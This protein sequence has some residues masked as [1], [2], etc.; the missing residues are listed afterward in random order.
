MKKAVL[1]F[2]SRLPEPMPRGSIGLGASSR[3]DRATAPPILDYSRYLGLPASPFEGGRPVLFLMQQMDDVRVEAV[4]GKVGELRDLLFDEQWKIR[5]LVVAGGTWLKQRRVTLPPTMIEENNWAHRELVIGGLT[6][7]QV[8]ASPETEKHIP[9][10]Q[11]GALEDVTTIA[12]D[13]YWAQLALH[14]WQVASDPELRSVGAVTGYQVE[15][16]DATLG[17]LAD[18][19]ID[20]EAWTIKYLAVDT[21]PWRK[22]RVL[23]VAPTHVT[24]LD[25]ETRTMR[26]G[27]S[28]ETLEKC[29]E[30]GPS[31]E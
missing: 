4:D 30:L 14:P 1:E 10:H 16:V 5:S 18:F 17:H 8:V 23:F 2:N 6:R 25:W 28:R 29:S 12:W 13:V 26:L 9:I 3:N 15:G 24:V 7:H 31:V 19:V 11:P 22:G 21:R 27:L 20:V